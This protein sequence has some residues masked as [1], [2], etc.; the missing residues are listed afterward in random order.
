[1]RH[2]QIFLNQ[3]WL[4]RESTDD[5]DQSGESMLWVWVRELLGVLLQWASRKHSKKPFIMIRPTNLSKQTFQH[6]LMFEAVFD[7]LAAMSGRGVTRRNGLFRPVTKQQCSWR[8][9]TYNCTE[10]GARHRKQSELE[11]YPTV[12]LQV[13]QLL[14]SVPTLF[15]FCHWKSFFS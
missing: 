9:K 3:I 4:R 10:W 1:M 2:H 6:V 14:H 12:D 13:F 8:R 7:R 5:S 15:K 11:C